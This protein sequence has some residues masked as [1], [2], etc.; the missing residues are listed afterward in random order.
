M[1]HRHRVLPVRKK[2]I[3]ICSTCNDKMLCLPEAAARILREIMP[4]VPKLWS[5]L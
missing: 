4:A 2:K 5:G 3:G 1:E